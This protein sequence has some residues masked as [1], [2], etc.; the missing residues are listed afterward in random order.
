MS[1]A[2][3]VRNAELVTIREAMRELNRIVDALEDGTLDKLVLTQRNRMRAVLVSLD[4]FVALELAAEAAR[5]EAGRR[6]A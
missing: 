4:R 6:A 1:D 3:L 2:I 5:R